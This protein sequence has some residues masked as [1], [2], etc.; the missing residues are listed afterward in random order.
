MKTTIVLTLC[1]LLALPL[2]ATAAAPATCS[3]PCSIV[4]TAEA[5]KLPANVITSGTSV[6]F[7]SGDISHV[8]TDGAPVGAQASCFQ[9]SQIPGTPSPALTFTITGGSLVASY[10]DE[11]GR[12]QTATCLNAIALP[13]GGFALPFYC[14]LHANMRGLLVVEP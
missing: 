6:V 3:D 8:T 4:A 14:K 9:L 11:N 2:F 7:S 1:A 5:Y 10:V 12:T 13:D